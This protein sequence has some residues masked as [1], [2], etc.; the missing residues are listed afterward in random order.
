LPKQNRR[1]KWNR[2]FGGNAN[3]HEAKDEEDMC[4]SNFPR[5][6]GHGFGARF[7]V[8][9]LF[10]KWRPRALRYALA[11]GARHMT[12]PNALLSVTRISQSAR[13]ATA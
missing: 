8:R 9:F 10:P 7:T 3:F 11:R 12:N 2:G 5:R 6:H 13:K 1:P 4:A